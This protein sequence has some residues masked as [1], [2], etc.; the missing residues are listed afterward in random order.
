[1]VC[2]GLRGELA[3]VQPCDEVVFGQVRVES[4][5]VVEITRDSSDVHDP[6]KEHR[7]G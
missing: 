7:E 4:L 6:I 2:A 3:V 1:V 5:A